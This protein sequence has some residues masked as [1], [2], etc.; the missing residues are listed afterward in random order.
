MNK[1]QKQLPK[2]PHEIHDVEGRDELP[3]KLKQHGGEGIVPVPEHEEHVKMP[4]KYGR[5][6]DCSKLLFVKGEPRRC[7]QN[8]SGLWAENK[9]L[10]IVTGY[11]LREPH[12]GSTAELWSPHSWCWDPGRRR[13][14]ETTVPAKK[15]FGVEL[16]DF[17]ALQFV[18]DNVPWYDDPKYQ[19]TRI[20]KC[21]FAFLQQLVK[22]EDSFLASAMKIC[23][24]NRTIGK[25][26]YKVSKKAEL[27]L[28]GELF[29]HELNEGL[30]E[31]SAKKMGRQSNA[32]GKKRPRKT[33]TGK[34]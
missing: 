26:K 1:K 15:Y 11:A 23:L 20:R 32:C 27:A 25:L 2:T 30:K 19:S 33:A 21:A 24:A 16:N 13:L 28:M 10:H 29:L 7:H 31:H 4:L 18:I 34:K 14:I 6:F 17:Q 22:Q 3:I 9:H 12:P 5:L 8:T